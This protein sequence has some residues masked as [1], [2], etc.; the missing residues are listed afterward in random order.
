MLFLVDPEKDDTYQKRHL[1]RC[2]QD[3]HDR[4]G[5]LIC[6]TCRGTCSLGLRGGSGI[7]AA[8]RSEGR[9]PWVTGDVFFKMGKTGTGGG[10]GQGKGNLEFF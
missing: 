2:G 8:A 6:R 4:F 1:P 5:K 7:R 3:T 9:A 10:L